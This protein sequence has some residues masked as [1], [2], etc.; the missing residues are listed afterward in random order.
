MTKD[1]I[2]SYTPDF[3]IYHVLDRFTYRQ[4]NSKI[5]SYNKVF[6]EGAPPVNGKKR[7]NK[8][9]TDIEGHT[10]NILIEWK[11]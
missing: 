7:T 4:D 11:P 9:K 10:G 5:L 8:L 6:F 1:L 3:K 2:A